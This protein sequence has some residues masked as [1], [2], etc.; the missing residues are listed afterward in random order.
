ME[1]ARTKSTRLTGLTFLSLALAATFALAGAEAVV[2]GTT[3]DGSRLFV[4]ADDT[5]WGA[6]APD[7]TIWGAPKPDDTIWGAPKPV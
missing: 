5:I 1:R 2:S 4:F 7:D 6:P 3:G